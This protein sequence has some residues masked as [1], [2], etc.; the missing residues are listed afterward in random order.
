MFL[1]DPVSGYLSSSHGL[2]CT[3]TIANS[4]THV[5][6]GEPS[7]PS[8]GITSNP[9]TNFISLNAL[10]KYQTR[11]CY[12]GLFNKVRDFVQNILNFSIY[13]LF[14]VMFLII[15]PIRLLHG[16]SPLLC[17]YTISIH[18]YYYLCM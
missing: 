17:R 6:A 2:H 5:E 14:H 10:D 7:I 1:F 12:A 4:H 16:T 11:S 9:N 8:V 15:L 13:T 3:L 18:S